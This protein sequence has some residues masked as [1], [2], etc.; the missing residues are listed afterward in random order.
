M[1]LPIQSSD[2]FYVDSRGEAFLGWDEV[3]DRKALLKEEAFSSL[4]VV[5]Q[6]I[7]V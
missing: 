5:K 4:T 1:S 6:G 7:F 3:I 2:V